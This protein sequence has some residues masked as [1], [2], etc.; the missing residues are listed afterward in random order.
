MSRFVHL[1]THSEYS[2]LDGH[3]KIE[4]L[5]DRAAELDMPALA[6]TD[7]GVMFGAV[8]FYKA[9]TFGN[10]KKGR[11][12][13]KPVIGCEIYFTPDSRKKRDGKP[14]L[15]HLLLLARND[16]GYRNLMAMVSE[17]WT[18]GFYYKPQVDEDLLRQY[19]DGLIATSACMSG[20]ISKSFEH[21]QPE[22]ARRWAETYASIFGEKNF[23]LE[24]QEQGIITDAGVSQKDLNRQIV[25]LA[26]EMGLPVIATNDIHYT[27][28]AHAEAQDMLVCI[29]TGKTVDDESRMK[30]SS[31]QFYLKTAE[32][33]ETALPEYPQASPSDAT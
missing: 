1:H 24:I 29:Q 11:A 17:A 10:E 19:S 18:S 12:P 8:E 15:N 6:L 3:A 14:R 26:D 31:D 2:L 25:G 16:T 20:I 9:A 28:A 32:E 7:H 23:Y 4:G 27:H 5:L 33:M 13:I 21:H 30:F 22:E